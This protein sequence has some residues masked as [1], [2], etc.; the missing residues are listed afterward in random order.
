MDFGSVDYAEP[1]V[2][3]Y[4]RSRVHGYLRGLNP[5]QLEKFMNF[6]GPRF[7]IV[8][9]PVAQAFSAKIRPEWKTYHAR[10]FTIVK[11][12]PTDLTMILKQS[13]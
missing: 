5:D 9:T 6:P 12:R 8:P 4:F 13:Q 1:S 10:G 2:V 3:W 11:G 7:A